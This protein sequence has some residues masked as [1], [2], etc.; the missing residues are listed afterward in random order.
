[1]RVP[2][3][4][5]AIPGDRPVTL[6]RQFGY[7]LCSQ[8]QNNNKDNHAQTHEGGF[9]ALAGSDDIQQHRLSRSAHDS[10]RSL[11]HPGRA[12]PGPRLYQSPRSFRTALVGGPDPAAGELRRTFPDPHRLATGR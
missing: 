10:T 6:A 9:D 11:T 5:L 2:E 1:M 3:P 12:G 8:C 7:S 4:T